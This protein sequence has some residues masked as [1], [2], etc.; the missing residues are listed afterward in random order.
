MKK[1]FAALAFVCFSFCL[2]SA[3]QVSDLK[4]FHNAGQTFITYKEV[5]PPAVNPEAM[6]KEV[7]D[8]VKK[9]T[10][11]TK[12]CYRIY[13]SDKPIK[14]VDG[15][16]PIGE[17]DPLGCWEWRRFGSDYKSKTQKSE[18]FVIKDGEEPL[19]VGSGLYVHN[20]LKEGS[21]YYA[22]TYVDESGNENKT[23]GAGN[24]SSA[25]LAEKPGRGEPVLQ[26]QQ[27]KDDFNGV[28]N[29][30]IAL[31][32]RW[33]SPP[34][35]SIENLPCG[36]LVGI[37]P[38]PAKPSPV[39]IGLH[40]WGGSPWNGY[41]WWYG[42]LKQGGSFMIAPNQVPYDWWT[43]YNEN[44]WDGPQNEQKWKEGKI[45]PY[46]TTRI[47]SFLDW[48]TAKYDLDPKRVHLGGV[49]MGGSGV[50]MFA[51]RYPERFAWGVS[52]VGVHNPG[53]TP[54]YQGGY[55]YAYGKKAWDLDFED[56]SKV[57]DHYNDCWYL[58]KHPEKDI[59]FIIFANG[60]NDI[61]IGWPQA[62]DFFHALQDTKQPHIFKWGMGDHGQ[63]HAMPGNVYDARFIQMDIRSDRTLPAFSKCSLDDDPGT[64]KKLDT[65]IV[66]PKGKKDIFD[67]V[68][69]G[70]VNAYLYWDTENLTDDPKKWEMGISL[71]KKAPKDECSVD[72]TPR[73][74][75]QFKLKAG[76]KLS[77]TC[78]DSSGKTL[79]E[80]QISADAN[81]L[82]T[83]EKVP[84]QK[85]GVRLAF[86]K[87]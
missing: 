37:P 69:D 31:Y 12:S 83:A 40:C 49:S 33:E 60:K 36:Y 78:K 59:P 4:I 38:N 87:K 80:G 79:A 65:P 6:A 27:N 2:V 67:G 77:W 16:K 63:R 84:V 14:S 45:R 70:Q 25:P 62:L 34:N 58:R 51:I 39:E 71:D 43:G 44:F 72:V 30:K 47:L 73:R 76:E 61:G 22:V 41:G 3:D 48:A 75:Q 24:S 55:E 53:N 21:S 15:M 1:F 18:R 7:Y 13:K 82:A 86:E 23:I 17:A 42:H 56:G 5:N 85:A 46:T 26:Y 32:V 81:G 11:Q 68:H 9:F 29:S 19:P 66:T 50:P 8:Q 35:A 57:W 54:Q 52:W 74:C 28:R 64:A 10:D 20:P